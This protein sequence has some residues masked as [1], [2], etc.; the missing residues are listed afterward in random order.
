MVIDGTRE[1]VGSDRREVAVFYRA[2]TCKGKPDWRTGV[3]RDDQARA[4]SQGKRDIA[5]RFLYSS[6]AVKVML[7]QA[8]AEKS[9]PTSDAKSNQQP[10]CTG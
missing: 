8:S 10:K 9:E 7:F 6:P 5:A 1:M 4:R 3:Q 2:A